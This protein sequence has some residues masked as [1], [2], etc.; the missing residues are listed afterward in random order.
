MLSKK[1]DVEENILYRTPDYFLEKIIGGNVMIAIDKEEII[2]CVCLHRLSEAVLE[3]GSA[4]VAE[5]YRGKGIYS[6]LKD[7]AL[8]HAEMFGREIISTAKVS[9]NNPSPG[10]SSS[11]SRKMLPIS[12]ETLRHFDQ[13]A[14]EACC[15]C[16]ERR[17]YR[18][19]H[20][21]DKT[22]ILTA[23]ISDRIGEHL[24]KHFI[25]T[26]EW[27]NAAINNNLKLRIYNILS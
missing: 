13:A 22:C 9:T 2:G 27:N 6:L 18:S 19:C 20:E 5:P 17:N 26:D 14:Y 10:L 15:N 4:W 21:R 24:A 3:I 16:D 11:L 1:S 8:R 7:G 25:S 12:F 23:K